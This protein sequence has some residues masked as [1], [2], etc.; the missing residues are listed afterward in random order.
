LKQ[1]QQQR[2]PMKR[3][4]RN[5]SHQSGTLTQIASFTDSSGSAPP[6]IFYLVQDSQGAISYVVYYSTNLEQ[7]VTQ[8]YSS[9]TYGQPKILY[10]DT[11]IG[12]SFASGLNSMTGDQTGSLYFIEAFPSTDLGGNPTGLNGS[13]VVDVIN[14]GTGTINTLLTAQ[15]NTLGELA[16]I[17]YSAGSLYFTGCSGVTAAGPVCSTASVHQTF[18]IVS[19]NIMSEKLSQLFSVVGNHPTGYI[20]TGPNGVYW[21]YRTMPNITSTSPLQGTEGQIVNGVITNGK[22]VQTASESFPLQYAIGAWAGIGNSGMHVSQNGNVFELYSVFQW[23]SLK[24]DG[25]PNFSPQV[26]GVDPNNLI[27]LNPSTGAYSVIFS[28]DQ[29]SNPWFPFF[30]ID[31][32][33]NLFVSTFDGT[34]IVEIFAV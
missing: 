18:S 19:L 5:H 6:S 32:S 24:P 28:G 20:S 1:L 25:T 27:W 12:A 31:T 16:Q 4:S 22:A 14:S 33:G 7:I 26:N 30:T 10:Q 13:E 23:V 34:S 15:L 3:L 21:S 11:N 29:N 8:T 2:R 17:T 9:G